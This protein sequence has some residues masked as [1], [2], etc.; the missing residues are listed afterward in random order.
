MFLRD[1]TVSLTDILV[2]LRLAL[3]ERSICYSEIPFLHLRDAFYSLMKINICP[4]GNIF[5]FI[6]YSEMELNYNMY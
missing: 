6:L 3:A 4:T 1:T 5:W 2:P